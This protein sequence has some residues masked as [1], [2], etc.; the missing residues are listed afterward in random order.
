MKFLQS[1]HFDWQ[2]KAGYSKK[3]FLNEEDLNHPGALV[4]MIKIKARDEAKSHHHKEQTE[5]FYFL[6]TNG[7]F[8]VNGEK[9][10]PAVGD[11]IVIEPGD[12]H[13][14]TNDTDEDFLYVAFKIKYREDDCYWD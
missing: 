14:V 9:I 10:R 7:F 1:D 2:D 4:Q 5:V 8:T 11:I 13:I 6:N 3:I 12:T